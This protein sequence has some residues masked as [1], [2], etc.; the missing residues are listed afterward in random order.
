[1]VRRCIEKGGVTAMVLMDL[2]KA[3]DCLPHNLLIAKLD[4][5][6]V[7]AD[8]AKL[9]FSYLTDRK[10]KVKAG[11][12]FTTWKCLSKGVPQGF[13]LINVF[14]NDFFYAIEHSQ[15]CNFAGDDTTFACG[16]TLN[17][18]TKSIENDM[19]MAM[20]WFKLNEM[21][22]NPEKFQIIFSGLNEDHKLSIGIDG[23]AIKISDT[24]K[25]LD[26][27]IG[28]KLRVNEYVKSICQKTN[29]KVKAFS[30]VRRYLEPQK[31][32]LLY[33]LFVL[34]NF[35]YCQL[36]WMF[37]GKTTVST[38]SSLL[39][40]CALKSPPITNHSFL[41]F[42]ASCSSRF[43]LYFLMSSSCFPHIGW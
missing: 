3:Y 38:L 37:C 9:V 43:S 8:S 40:T 10:Q 32:S 20:N 4:P 33:N 12:S 18:V 16:E 29:N 27:T 21:V 11:Y 22:S 24:V 23:D 41:L 31:V 1:M 17:E 5:Y 6:G 19:G 26:V 30:R 35:N 36:I 15:V 39:P 7:G 13:V 2:S 28:S 14:I 42:K 25:L 34:T